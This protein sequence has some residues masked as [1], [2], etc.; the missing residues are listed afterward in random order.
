MELGR[1]SG[2]LIRRGGT[3]SREAELGQE[4]GVWSEAGELGQERGSLMRRG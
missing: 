4:G 1:E 2:N 3:W